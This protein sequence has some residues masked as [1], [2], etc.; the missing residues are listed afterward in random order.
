[1]IELIRKFQLKRALRGYVQILGPELR[2][3]YGGSDQYTVLQIKKT[4]AHLKLDIQYL[5]YA[6][7]MYRHEQ[8]KNTV[9]MLRLDQAFLNRLRAEV[10]DALL[11][12]NPNY[13]ARDVLALSKKVK[14]KGGPSPHWWS[15][16]LGKTSL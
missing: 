5:P 7:A 11:D 4:V 10:A 16:N 12:G 9:D 13:S 15:N 2:K 3:R 1:M 8:S 6:V 14:W